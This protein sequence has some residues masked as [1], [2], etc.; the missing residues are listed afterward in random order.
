MIFMAIKHSHKISGLSANPIEA[1]GISSACSLAPTPPA[2]SYYDPIKSVRFQHG[3][4][5][6]QA[7]INIRE[8]P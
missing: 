6:D 1:A 2:H 4:N 7:L 8:F 5:F 3:L